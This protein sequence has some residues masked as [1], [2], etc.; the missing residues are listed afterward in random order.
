LW[1]KEINHFLSP[2][3]Y[4]KTAREAV[5]TVMRDCAQN[6]WTVSAQRTYAYEVR[7]I[8]D[9]GLLN[10]P[11]LATAGE[12]AGDVRRRFVIIDD[13]IEGVWGERIRTY[14]RQQEV[15][16]TYHILPPG[17]D[18]KTPEVAGEVAD[19]M[20]A[21]GIKRRREPL[22]VM[23]G[24]AALDAG[25][26]VASFLLRGLEWIAVPFSLVGMIDV[27]LGAK[28]AVNRHGAK[29]KWGAFHPASVRLIDPNF[30]TTL[31]QHRLSEGLAE[32]AKATIMLDRKLTDRLYRNGPNLL[33]RGFQRLEDVNVMAE[34]IDVTVRELAANLFESDL[35]RLMDFGHTVSHQIEKVSHW[36]VPHGVAVG[37]DMALSIVLARRRELITEEH[38]HRLLALLRRLGLDL[39]TKYLTE[40]LFASALIDR[41]RHRGGLLRMILPVHDVGGRAVNDVTVEECISAA[42]ELRER[43]A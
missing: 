26:Y 28:V 14:F 9:G 22:I 42:D 19:A 15:D 38:S 40:D 31:P 33:R 1:A 25:G 12:N 16:A 7:V 8:R 2:P 23:G 43:T 32:M 29:N 3:A 36:A 5:V 10:T 21:W 17:E 20:S 37:H 24:G 30:L 39:W 18:A 27:A 34:V 4:S 13:G 6:I 11:T 41:T 35:D